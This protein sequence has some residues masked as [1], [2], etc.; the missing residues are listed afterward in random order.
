MGTVMLCVL[1]SEPR[2]VSIQRC[3]NFVGFVASP[4][5]GGKPFF[6]DCPSFMGASMS[7]WAAEMAKSP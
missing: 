6:L 1:P 7:A 5:M 3:P 4:L 2:S